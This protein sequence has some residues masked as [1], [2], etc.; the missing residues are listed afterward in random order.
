MSSSATGGQ[1]VF[2]Y[3]TFLQRGLNLAD[4]S[5]IPT[6]RANLGLSTTNNLTI[7]AGLTPLNGTYNFTAPL[8]VKI[9]R[10]HV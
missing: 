5:D 4:L 3:N 2:N 7:G 1:L 6:A 10:A 8:T 9:G